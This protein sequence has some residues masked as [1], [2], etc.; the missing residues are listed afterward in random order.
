MKKHQLNNNPTAMREITKEELANNPYF[1][2][3][4]QQGVLLSLT[5]AKEVNVKLPELAEM[6]KVEFGSGEI[7]EWHSPTP[8]TDDTKTTPPL[9][10][11]KQKR[12]GKGSK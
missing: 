10:K 7:T 4:V 1:R 8:P 6:H 3:G 12:V 11:P 2:L 9:H 5:K